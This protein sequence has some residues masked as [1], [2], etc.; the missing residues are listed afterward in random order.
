M[1]KIC[2]ADI[3][4]MNEYFV[5]LRSYS[6]YIWCIFPA[7]FSKIK[8]SQINHMIKHDINNSLYFLLLEFISIQAIYES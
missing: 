8:P 1:W 4:F 7:D 5:I 6:A 2:C 3:K